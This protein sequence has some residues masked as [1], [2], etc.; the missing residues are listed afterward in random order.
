MLQYLP[1]PPFLPPERGRPGQRE[2]GGPGTGKGTFSKFIMPPFFGDFGAAGTA[3][4]GGLS[5]GAAKAE[6]DA[7]HPDGKAAESHG[8]PELAEGEIEAGKL[9]VEEIPDTGEQGLSQ[10]GGGFKHGGPPL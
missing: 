4:A 6:N 7:D 2:A 1:Y 9:I 3:G 8:N 5:S 10:G